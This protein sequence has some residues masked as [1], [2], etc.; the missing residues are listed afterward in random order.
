V[1]LFHVA[2]PEVQKYLREDENIVPEFGE[3]YNHNNGTPYIEHLIRQI[4]ELQRFAVLYILRNPNFKDFKFTRVQIFKLWGELYYW[5]LM[6]INLKPA[7]NDPTI[8]K[9][10]A[11]HQK[12]PDLRMIRLLPI[13]FVLYVQRHAANDERNSQ[14]DFLQLCLYVGPS[15]TVPGAIRAAMLINKHLHI[16]TT[17]AIKGVSDGGHVAIYPTSN[18]SNITCRH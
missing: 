12:K 14:H 5:T 10:Q 11:F 4:K 15:S 2:I 13:F 3:A 6:I 18:S 8:T 1:S 7:F 9:Y 17:T 16:I